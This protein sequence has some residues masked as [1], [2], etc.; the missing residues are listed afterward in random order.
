MFS[1]KHGSAAA[2]SAAAVLIGWIGRLTCALAGVL[3]LGAC[4]ALFGGRPTPTSVVPSATPVPPTATPPPLAAIVNGEYIALA[5]YEIELG[6]FHA[7]QAALGSEVD[8]ADAEGTVLDDMIAQVLLSQAAR[9]EGLE[10][11]TS[12]LQEREAALES[13]SGDSYETW[14]AAHGYS[15]ESFRA[16]LKRAVEAALMRDKIIAEVPL[17]AP[18]VHVRQILAYNAADAE[19]VLQRLEAGEDFD[20]IAAL[21][22]QVTHGELGWIAEGYLLDAAA[23]EAV[24]SLAA[25]E[26]SGVVETDAG[27]HI[28]KVIERATRPLAPD[29]LLQAQQSALEAWVEAEIQRSQIQIVVR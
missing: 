13:A 16:A 20:A 14:K 2:R 3:A 28:F 8:D 12:D 19:V 10:A 1:Q 7:A 6:Q 17:Q 18:Q 15:D 24:F 21:S 29:A 26:F 22:D 11:T 4:S 9:R 25:G 5:D 27:Y 23:N